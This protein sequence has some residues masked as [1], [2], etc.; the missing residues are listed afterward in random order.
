MSK[1]FQKE[2]VNKLLVIVNEV[3]A[4]NNSKRHQ[5][6]LHELI[7]T[8]RMKLSSIHHRSY[9]VRLFARIIFL[10]D[11]QYPNKI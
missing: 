8:E 7:T 11:R 2:L 4:D 5:T 10:I 9:D 3:R 6:E 1:F